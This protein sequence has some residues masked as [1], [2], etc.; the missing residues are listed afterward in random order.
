MPR[1]LLFM[2][3]FVVLHSCVSKPA[4]APAPARNV[5]GTTP[6]PA[7]LMPPYQDSVCRGYAIP[8]GLLPTRCIAGGPYP[9]MLQGVKL[10][11]PGDL[12]GA[13]ESCLT[14]ADCTGITADWYIDG[15]FTAIRSSGPFVPSDDA[16]GCTFLIACGDG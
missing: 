16:Y 2:A 7:T 3:G 13:V 15:D 6:A 8:D 14:E 9:G 5:Q 1:T 12:S 10:G 4:R 11:P